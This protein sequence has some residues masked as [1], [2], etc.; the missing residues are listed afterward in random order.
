MPKSSTLGQKVITVPL[1]KCAYK[2]KNN[3]CLFERLCRYRGMAFFNFK[4][5]V[6]GIVTFLYYA[7]KEIET[8]KRKYLQNIAAVFVSNKRIRLTAS[9]LSALLAPV[10]FCEKPN[11][12][13]CSPW[14]EREGLAQNTH[15]TH[16]ALRLSI[17]LL[18]V[19]EPCLR[20]HMRILV[21]RKTDPAV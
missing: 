14:G 18:G 9:V 16:I 5:L 2:V 21:F 19:D 3:S 13:V 4:Y 1:I 6:L 7:S 17:R 12:P 10:T 11:M 20:Q 8:L 15:G